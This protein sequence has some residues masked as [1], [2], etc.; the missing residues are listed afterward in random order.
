MFEAIQ[1][2]RR[3][4]L[5]IALDPD[6]NDAADQER[7]GDGQRPEEVRLDRLAEEEP[8]RGRGKEADGE[9]DRE[10][11]RQGIPREEPR[12]PREKQRAV[13]NDHGQ[14]RTE[15]DDDLEGLRTLA[16]L[17]EQVTDE[18]EVTRGRDGEVFGEPLDDAEDQSHEGGHAVPV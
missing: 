9:R 12:Q 17:A 13:V 14:D 3:A 8:G 7:Y 6:H 15:L 10:R 1:D 5:S 2:D 4:C 18:D 11:Y 16:V